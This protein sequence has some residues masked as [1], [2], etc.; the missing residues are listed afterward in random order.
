MASVSPLR[1]IRYGAAHVELEELLAPPYD[2][3]RVELQNQLLSRNPHNILAIDN[4]AA[5]LDGPPPGAY[6]AAARLLDAWLDAEVLNQ[7]PSPSLYVVAHRFPLPSGEGSAER[8]GLLALAPAL[9][10]TERAVLPHEHTFAGPKRDRLELM[11]ATRTQTSPIF[12]LWE[13]APLVREHLDRIMTAAPDSTAL[14]QGDVGDENL[15]LWRVAHDRAI[16][17]VTEALTDA[18]LYIADGHHRY[19]TAVAYAGERDSPRT[20]AGEPRVLAYF[21][22]AHDPG[23]IILPTHRLATFADR[24]VPSLDTIRQQ[25]GVEWNVSPIP[26]GM[27]AAKLLESRTAVENHAFV[28]VTKDERVAFV[29]RKRRRDSPKDGLDVQVLHAELLPAFGLGPE[30][31]IS[32]ERDAGEAQSA[33]GAGSA[34]I[35]FILAAPSVDELLRVAGAGESMPQ[36]STYFYPKVPTGL[37]LYRMGDEGE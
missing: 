12:V 8:V 11:R 32:F 16:D 33:I 31:S 5:G 17:A 2:V 27:N 35:A 3:V 34:D 14:Y 10:W 23:M 13:G 15:R 1:G 24:A 4:P 6:M 19:E 25:L 9:P 26:E 22:D 30:D 28:I 21:A 36:K 7:D 29:R 20:R 18:V 37:V